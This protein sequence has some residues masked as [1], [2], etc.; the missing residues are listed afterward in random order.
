MIGQIYALH[1]GDY[2]YRYVGVTTKTAQ[3]RLF[4]HCRRA[5]RHERYPVTDW[6]RSHAC[7]VQTQLLEEVEGTS[8]EIYAAEIKWIAILDTYRNGLN[9]TT[10]GEGAIGLVRTATHSARIAESQRG[11]TLSVETR[12]KISESKRGKRLSQEAYEKM[13]ATNR[14][15]TRTPEQRKNISDSLKGRVVPE[16]QKQRMREGHKKRYFCNECKYMSSP[17]WVGRHQKVTGHAGRTI[18]CAS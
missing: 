15:R 1:A 4:E 13:A 9:C 8:D 7:N 3:D 18:L 11:K 14:G 5:L 12:K 10:G 2:R 6:I 16:D 17:V